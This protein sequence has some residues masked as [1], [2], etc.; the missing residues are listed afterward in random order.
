MATLSELVMTLPLEL[1][2]C[3]YRYATN[4]S[5]EER[6]IGIEFALSE[7]GK[8]EFGTF[9]AP[10]L[11]ALVKM[12][13]ISSAMYEEAVKHLTGLSFT[14]VLVSELQPHMYL[15]R[16]LRKSYPKDAL[17]RISHIR[18]ERMTVLEHTSPATIRIFSH[19]EVKYGVTSES[20][21]CIISAQTPYQIEPVF[22]THA[23][24]LI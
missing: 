24:T 16:A 20:H 21:T 18:L 3:I 19:V 22:H 11:D 17:E 9:V 2:Q 1:R 15:L 5:N 6:D 10:V 12:K 7:D 14:W 4:D 8:D 13:E 23:S